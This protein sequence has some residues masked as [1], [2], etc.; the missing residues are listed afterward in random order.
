MVGRVIAQG[1]EWVSEFEGRMRE[2]G[3]E[4]ASCVAD[5]VNAVQSCLA[6]LESRD[7]TRQIADLIFT[8]SR[9]LPRSSFVTCATPMPFEQGR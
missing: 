4:T 1:L 8:V 9:R 7:K 3:L 6:E 2:M 5:H